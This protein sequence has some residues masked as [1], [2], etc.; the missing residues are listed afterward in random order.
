MRHP[1][2]FILS[3][4][5]YRDS[6]AFEGA[7]LHPDQLFSV[8]DLHHPGLEAVHVAVEQGDLT[9]AA[10]T[11]LRYYRERPSVAWPRWPAEQSIAAGRAEGVEDGAGRLEATPADFIAASNALRHVFQPYHAYPP[12]DYG[13]EIDWDWDP[14]GNIEWPAHMHRMSS[15]DLSAARCYSSMRSRP[16]MAARGSS[17][18]ASMR[19]SSLT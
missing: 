12:T 1:I 6:F 16:D 15:W 19:A 9:A 10:T 14:H 18:P 3:G 8:L 7:P 4:S 17:S 2:P 13:P 11:L 5:P